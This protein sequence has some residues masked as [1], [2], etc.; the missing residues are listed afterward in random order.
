M[1][2]TFNNF[3]V[4]SDVIYITCYCSYHIMLLLCSFVFVVHVFDIKMLICCSC[5]CSSLFVGVSYCS[6]FSDMFVCV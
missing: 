6:P 1:V 2:H 4:Q 3:V 5:C